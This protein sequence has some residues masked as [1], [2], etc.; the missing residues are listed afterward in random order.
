MGCFLLSEVR[1]LR[2]GPSSVVE[3]QVPHLPYV[4]CLL[5]IFRGGDA[6]PARVIPQ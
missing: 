3:I 4:R 6:H 2:I 1:W 5:D